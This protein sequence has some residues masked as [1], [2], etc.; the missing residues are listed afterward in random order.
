MLY[1]DV[2]RL[3]TNF[4]TGK[5]VTGVDKVALAYIAEFAQEAC[6]VIRLPSHWLFFDRTRSDKIFTHLLQHKEIKLSIWDKKRYI[7]PANEPINVLLNVTHS[8]L[9]SPQYLT[10]LQQ[11]GLRGVYFLHDLIPID[12]PEYCRAGEYD[13]HVQRLLTMLQGDLIIANSR[14]TLQRLEV[15]CKRF[16]YVM[17]PTVWAHLAADPKDNIK[18]ITASERALMDLIV[19][20]KNYFVCLG[21]IEGRKNHL[22]L[23]NVWRQLVRKLGKN[24]PKLVLIGKRGWEAEQVFDM[25]DRSIELHDVV[26]ELNHCDN[27]QIN[28][29]LNHAQA[30]LFPSWAEGFGLP[31]LESLQTN[32][33]VIASDIPAFREIATETVRLIS[34]FD[35]VAWHQ[36]ILKL[37]T[38]DIK[39]PVL[40]NI[41]PQRDVEAVFGW[42]I[43][44]AY[45][46]PPI[47]KVLNSSMV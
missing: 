9:D 32:T 19:G 31:L 41:N 35:E 28:Y 29:L 4:R 40:Q 45:T 2:T 36:A 39:N 42:H 43:H 44:F 25:L 15:F 1:L 8:G 46:K 13:R 24:C 5:G 21:T 16:N 20:K 34:P 30:L 26:V 38:S 11:Y 3:Y 47:T 23:L 7:K 12:Y 14:Y 22:L 27:A 37:H 33:Q 10:R 17:P 6:A 18:P